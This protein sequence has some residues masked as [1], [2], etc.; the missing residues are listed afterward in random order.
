[1][2]IT[3]ILIIGLLVIGLTNCEPK[4]DDNPEY[5]NINFKGLVTSA[6]NGNP[7]IGIKVR[8]KCFSYSDKPETYTDSLGYFYFES[9]GY[10]GSKHEIKVSDVDYLDNQGYF[11]AQIKEFTLEDASF[12]DSAYVVNFSMKKLE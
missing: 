7:I 5:R 8:L 3:F 12:N 2:K 9:K 1:M 4:E 6:E 11:E 10:A